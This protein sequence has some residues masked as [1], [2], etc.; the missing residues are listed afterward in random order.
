[1][2]KSK[3]RILFVGNSITRHAPKQEIGWL[4]D[5]GMAA[6]SAENDFVHLLMARIKAKL[7]DAGYM[8]I[9]A[10][11]WEREYESYGL[12]PRKGIFYNG[13]LVS[14][15]E[16]AIEEEPSGNAP[17]GRLLSEILLT[18]R[19]YTADVIIMRIIENVK[20]EYAEKYPLAPAY[21]NLIDF[22]N[23]G[24]KAEVILTTSFWAHP[25]DDEVR[26]VAAD[27]G[28]PLVELNNLGKQEEMM[29]TGLFEHKGV[30]RHPGDKGMKAIAD[31]IWDVL[32]KLNCF[33]K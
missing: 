20:K 8:T 18:A 5:W 33:E 24:R 9:Q 21:S 12:D 32:E 26:K 10:A 19:E 4:D 13:T 22:M 31:A 29:A 16:G 17:T 15:V 25:A 14:S 6:S 3:P 1:M 7:P 28:Y 11:G 27:R 23:T 2:E 30:A